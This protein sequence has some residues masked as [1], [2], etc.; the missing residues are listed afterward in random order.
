MVFGYLVVCT[1][2]SII[3][4]VPSFVLVDPLPI[5]W[6]IE[7]DVP[8]GGIWY[9]FKQKCDYKDPVYHIFFQKNLFLHKLITTSVLLMLF[10]CVY[11]ATC[12]NICLKWIELNTIKTIKTSICLETITCLN[13]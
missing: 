13:T 12:Y 7:A 11:Y 1:L 5:K 3:V 2:P 10:L 9:Y 4:S 8:S 6:Q